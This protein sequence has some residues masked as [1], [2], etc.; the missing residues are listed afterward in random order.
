MLLE[1]AAREEEGD[2]RAIGGSVGGVCAT[3]AVETP[4]VEGSDIPGLLGLAA[5]TN[6]RAVLDM[7]NKQL[8]FLVPG[9][10]NTKQFLPPGS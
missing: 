6:R 8:H 5:L 4:A 3:G 9:D 10:F 1:Q 7:V 2:T